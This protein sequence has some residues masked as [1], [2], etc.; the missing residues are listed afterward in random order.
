MHSFALAPDVT[1][2]EHPPE[3]IALAEEM[4]KADLRTQVLLNFNEAPPWMRK[5]LINQSYAA[6]NFLKGTPRM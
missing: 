5:R 2:V 4:F 3:I 6:F 1:N